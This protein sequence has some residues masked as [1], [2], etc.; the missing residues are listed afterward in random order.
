MLINGA[1]YKQTP[2]GGIRY[3]KRSIQGLLGQTEEQDELLARVLHKP[4]QAGKCVKIA[5]DMFTGGETI[6]DAIQN[7]KELMNILQ[8]NNLKISASKTVLFPKQ[9]DILSWVWNQGGF[10]SPSPHRKQALADVHPE[11]IKTIKDLQSWIGLYKTFLDCTPNLTSILD[12]FDTITGGED[13][14][15]AV[16]WT[17]ELTKRFHKAQLHIDNMTNIYLPQAEDQL[18]ITCDRA[19]TPPAVGMIL[20]ARTPSGQIKTV[21]FYSVKLKP[22]VTKWFPCEIEA[23]AVGT[24][25]E[26]FYDY[27]KQSNKPVI[28]CPD[29]KTVIDAANKIAKGHFSL[30]YDIQHVSRK[31]GQNAAGVFQSRSATEC[32]ADLCQ[33]C[34]YV[35]QHID[36]VID[37]KL[38]PYMTSSLEN[39]QHPS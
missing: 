33:I 22:H 34:N 14:K 20:Q 23:S 36:T 4:L 10:L 18:I 11:H 21:R 31:S 19:R 13:S 37:V 6:E 1:Q 39:Q 38:M 3:F 29:S 25:I 9:V 8:A 26:A 16:T 5:D 27:I 7:F 32:S 35:N 28:I 15:D 12:P 17:P 30:S 24:A 2:Y